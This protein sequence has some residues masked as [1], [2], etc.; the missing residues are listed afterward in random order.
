MRVDPF[1]ASSARLL[2]LYAEEELARR[3]GKGLWGHPAYR[4]RSA[5]PEELLPWIGSVQVFEGKVMTAG[6]GRRDLYLNFGSDW[7]Q[8]TTAR[9]Q[10][11]HLSVFEEAGLTAETLSGARVR[12]RGWLQSWN[13]PFLDLSQPAQVEL[14]EVA[15]QPGPE[16]G[17]EG[18]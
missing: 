7:Q 4:L 13:G 5:E 15:R 6:K 14:L 16:A 2:E 8:D 18:Q 11:Q 9:I 10:R 17:A 3:E 12:L 1:S